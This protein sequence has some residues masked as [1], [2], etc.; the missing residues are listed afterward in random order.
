MSQLDNFRESLKKRPAREMVTVT[1][2]NADT[3]HEDKSVPRATMPYNKEGRLK[4]SS[5]G[6][7]GELHAELKALCFWM[8]K[9][10][11]RN[12]P[13][14]TDVISEMMSAYYEVHP[15]AKEFVGKFWE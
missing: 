3:V 12:N 1:V 15:E 13:G 11:I 9:K 6:V 2:T 5:I 7:S 8:K 10:G 4:R 14:I